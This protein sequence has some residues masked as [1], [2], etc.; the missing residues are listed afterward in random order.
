MDGRD[1]QVQGLDL[2]VFG[3]GIQRARMKAGLSQLALAK[4]LNTSQAQVS[5][6]EL[7][8]RFAKTDRIQ[9]IAKLCGVSLGQLVRLGE[10]AKAFVELE[11]KENEGES[12]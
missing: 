12:T 6:Y 7:G 4:A 11:E 8:L 1:K 5:R 10:K 3:R 2:G 9:E